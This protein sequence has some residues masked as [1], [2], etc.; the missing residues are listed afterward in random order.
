[1][2]LKACYQIGFIGFVMILHDKS[3]RGVANI[4]NASLVFA[5]VEICCYYGVVYEA[6]PPP[7]AGSRAAVVFFR[8]VLS[9]RPYSGPSPSDC[10]V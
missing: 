2:N 10:N 8:G 3:R 5:A 6:Y 7:D 9:G 4:A 1:M